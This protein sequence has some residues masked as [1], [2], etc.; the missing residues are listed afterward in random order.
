MRKQLHNRIDFTC[1]PNKAFIPVLTKALAIDK[2]QRYPSVLIMLEEFHSVC[3][4]ILKPESSFPSSPALSGIRGQPVV[5]AR[6]K[7]LYKKWADKLLVPLLSLL[8][9]H[10]F[11]HSHFLSWA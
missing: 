6:W 11:L 8:Y 3:D 1:L 2:N 9:F 5:S 10:A 7:V 4:Q